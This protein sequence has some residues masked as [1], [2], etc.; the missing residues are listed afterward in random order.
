MWHGSI[1]IGGLALLVCLGSAGCGQ[2]SDSG[3]SRAAA[4]TQTDAGGPGISGHSGSGGS[5]GQAGPGGAAGDTSGRGGNAADAGQ[6]SNGGSSGQ[7]NPGGTAGDTTGS[8]GA[9][10]GQG[11]QPGGAVELSGVTNARQTGGLLATNGQ[12]LRANVLIRS[13]H[14][15]GLDSTGCAQF[16]ALGIRT[17]IDLRDADDA[18]QTPDASCA[19]DTAVYYNADLPKLL[20]P[21]EQSYLDTLDAAEP[22]LGEIFSRLGATDGLP[23]IVHCVIGRD[24]ASLVVALVL[25]SLG[26]PEDQVLLDFEQN[27]DSSVTV[28]PA[29]MAGVLARI[30]TA[31]GI[32]AYLTEH[33]VTNQE[34]VALRTGALE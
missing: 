27:Q 4:G 20:P 17:V 3:E 12:R 6:P 24:R 10:G 29:W 14:L 13:G 19:V 26:V 1:G 18:A 32:D 7:A 23:A 16:E 5:G 34:L 31:G 9:T 30:D 2:S 25:L 8:G 11:G 21:S 28:D 22:V 33:G 15:G